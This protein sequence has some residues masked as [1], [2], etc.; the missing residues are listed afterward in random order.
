MSNNNQPGGC[1]G[2]KSTSLKEIWSDLESGLNQIYA[3]QHM[4]KPRYMELYTQVYNYCTSAQN[5]QQMKTGPAPK[6]KKNV[7][8]GSNIGAEFIGMELY[9]KLKSF[10][11][12][13]VEKLRKQGE[14]FMDEGVLN[15]YVKQW[16]EFQF[17]SK[18]I[19]GICS[20][21]NRHW[22]RREMDEGNDN[23]YEIY[24]LALVTWKQTLFDPLHNQVTSAVL[25]LI[26][27]ERK[28]ETIN[29]CLVS[30][31]INCYVE[32]G[33]NE[34]VDFSTHG[35]RENRD[36]KLG[37][38]TSAFEKLFIEDTENFYMREAELF[39]QNNP[40]TEYVKRVEQRL[41]EEEHRCKLYLHKSTLDSLL[42]SCV[43]VL[44]QNHIEKFQTEFRNLLTTDKTE[45]LARMYDLCAKVEHGL[46]ELMRALEQHVLQQG[47][48]AVDNALDTSLTEPRAYVNTI[49]GVHKKYY[50]LVMT[51]FKSDSGFIASLDK[52]CG[53]FINNNAVTV[54]AN[55][56]SKSPELLARYCDILLRKSAKNPEENEIDDLLN[57][58]MIVFKYIDDKDVFQKFY[59]KMFAKRLV[60]QWSASDDSESSMI[61]KLKQA[62]GFEYTAKLQRMFTDVGL[63]KDLNDRFRDH[64]SKSEPLDIEFSIMVLSSGSWPFQ[65]GFSMNIPAELE[66]SVQRFTTFY[67]KQHSGRKLTWLNQLARSELIANCYDR[68]Y[69]FTTSTYQMAVLLQYNSCNEYTVQQLHDH[70]QIK[71]DVLQQVV[72]QLVRFKLLA[73]KKT[74]GKKE[75]SP[76]SSSSS[77]SST[78]NDEKQRQISDPKSLVL[79]TIVQQNEESTRC[80]S[81]TNINLTPETVVELLFDFKNKKLKIDLSKAPLKSEVKQEQDAV[82]KNIEEDR[83]LLIQAAIV[84]IMKMRKR[85]QHQHLISE[86]LQQLS[87]RFKPKVPIIKKMIDVLIEKEYLQ[88]LENERDTYE[89]LA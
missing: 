86:V 44:I 81:T 12:V 48:S 42:R 9:L 70:L 87:S 34:S 75:K 36:P 83:K 8:T 55:S 51:A 76:L 21:L 72:E 32:L 71:M 88:R 58:I 25:K 60:N 80:D 26:E 38:Y 28:G 57:Q 78:V 65:Q 85:L 30:G 52:A 89:Y 41:K 54:K 53:K 40:I 73:V 35:S 27:R 46:C 14:G 23:I 64:L 6:G 45:D 31:V 63:S 33:L 62:C 15:F 82:S 61:S 19:N 2:I 37:L 56:T 16:G 7:F 49:L 66:K 47:L 13:Y 79:T 11:Q 4:P 1:G 3:R 74:L 84:R 69:T 59:S 20:Y 24:N 43:K 68:K 77:S 50:D 22:I 29:A 17:S 67:A 10:F 39:L 18:V 5:P